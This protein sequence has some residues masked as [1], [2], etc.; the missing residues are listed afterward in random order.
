MS[1]AQQWR[2]ARARPMV[3]KPRLLPMDEPLGALDR[4]LREDMRIEIMRLHRNL[5]ITPQF[6]P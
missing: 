5:G 2:V 1:G 4:K 3:F 6:R